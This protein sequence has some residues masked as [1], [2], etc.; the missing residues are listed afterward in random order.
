MMNRP[1]MIRLLIG[2]VVALSV[3]SI[4]GVLACWHWRIWSIEDFEDY[5]AAQEYKLGPQ[6]WSGQIA[7][8]EEIEKLITD[9]PPDRIAR[10]APWT[11]ITYF[12]GVDSSDTGGVWFAGLTIIAKDSK[13]VAATMWTDYKPPREFIKQSPEDEAEYQAA[14][15]RYLQQRKA[16]QEVANELLHLIRLILRCPQNLLSIPAAVCSNICY[17]PAKF[18]PPA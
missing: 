12:P 10:F 3:A 9:V 16:K 15:L 17:L 5:Q 1:T 6:L 8:G 4:L 2:A 18:L 7:G 14:Y 13:V 11:E